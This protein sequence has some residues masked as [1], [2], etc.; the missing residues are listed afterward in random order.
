MKLVF[1]GGALDHINLPLCKAFFNILNN[2]FNFIATKS[3]S[4]SRLDLGY[5][6]LT[7]KYPFVLKYYENPKMCDHVIDIADVVIFGSA[8]E[9]IISKRMLSNKLTFRFTERMYKEPFS[10]S[11]FIHRVLGAMLHHGR[12][13]GKKVYILAAGAYVANDFNKYKFYK[14]R[15]YKWCYFTKLSDKTY[16]ELIKIKKNNTCT[17]LVWTARFVP[18][19]HPELVIG[20]ASY[21]KKLG[22]NFHISMVGGG[23]L[24][25]QTKM[26]AR[27]KSLEEYITFSG[28]VSPEYARNIM[29]K[30]DISLFTSDR[31][32]GWGAV[33]N[34]AMGS[35]CAIVAS[36]AAGSSPF[37]VE[38][39]KNGYLFDINNP[40]KFYERV[41]R[42]INDRKDV[43]RIGRKGYETI[44]KYWTPDNAA[45]SF[46]DL[47]KSI[48]DGS[49]KPKTL[50][51][52]SIAP[53]MRDEW[54]KEREKF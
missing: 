37:L 31:R 10:V 35:G 12:Y 5:G 44:H 19:K 13:Q 36:S 48:M 53:V 20:L 11:N 34:E 2:E 23:E 15:C 3:T 50:G 24:L 6:N 32:E 30:A 51:P 45:K 33:V 47:A 9:K 54:F 26:M 38:H 1:I 7:D 42:L 16:D 4:S 17:E 22:D 52:C 28:P 41:H 14:N 8:P 25:E 46:I 49:P 18:V 43:E 39:G 27:E 21:L 29:E 40:Q